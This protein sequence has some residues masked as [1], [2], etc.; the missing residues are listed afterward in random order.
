M[1]AYKRQSFDAGW[2]P[3]NDAFNA[4]AN[5]VLRMDNLTLDELGILSLRPGSAKI[6][7][8]ASNPAIY[9]P[10]EITAVCPVTQPVLNI[11]YTFR[12]RAIGGKPP[13]TWSKIAGTFPNSLI[14]QPTTGLF[15][16]L[17][18]EAGTFPYTV[19]ASDSSVPPQT[20]DIS[21]TATVSGLFNAVGTITIDHTL[22]G[23]T[24]DTAN[25]PFLFNTTDDAFKL[26]A[27]GGY[28]TDVNGYDIVFFLDSGLTIPLDFEVEKWDGSTGEFVA[29]VKLDNLSITVDTVIYV[30]IGNPAITTSQENI[31]GVWDDNGLDYFKLVMHLGNGIALSVA[32]STA[33][34]NNGTNNGATASSGQIDGSAAFDETMFQYV[35]VPNSADLELAFADLMT[36][37][38]WFKTGDPD[39]QWFFD[40]AGDP[41]NYTG[42]YF[43]L[44]AISGF[45]QMR[46]GGTAPTDG[47]FNYRAG[48]VGTDQWIRAMITYNGTGFN[49]GLNLSYNAVPQTLIRAATLT[50]EPVDTS[51]LNLGRYRYGNDRFLNG[52][53]D[54]IRVSKGILR[55]QDYD[56]ASYNNQFDPATFYALVIVPT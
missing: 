10:V 14:I 49:T 34:A 24:L 31:T 35:E 19:R 54:E 9:G 29:W 16:G 18:I 26:V 28:V 17:P 23:S 51:P 8:T 3:D 44:E 50:T 55:S 11:P 20:A 33:N 27:S 36:W 22:C 1:G 38:F 37:E 53:L 39:E 56:T 4:P 30:A 13:V 12:F 6:S 5:A 42:Y 47:I 25:F 43:R 40:K 15:G 41:P 2:R 45:L 46:I 52:K 48:D 21:C 7:Q 32:D